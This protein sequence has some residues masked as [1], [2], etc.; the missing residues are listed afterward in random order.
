[1]GTGTRIAVDWVQSS[2]SYGR[3]SGASSVS[4]AV[5]QVLALQRC[6]IYIHIR[7]GALLS[8]LLESTFLWATNAGEV[9]GIL[10][11]WYWF[12]KLCGSF[13]RYWVEGQPD[14]AFWWGVFCAAVVL[15]RSLTFPPFRALVFVAGC[16]P[17]FIRQRRSR[18]GA[19]TVFLLLLL[20]LIS[21]IWAHYC[22]VLA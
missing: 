1:M 16:Q 15:F 19:T 2:V 22:D 12:D 5:Y 4:F 20:L 13:T 18:Q 14:L 3:D 8:P 17:G 6:F 9:P 10:A 11:V 7:F 21:Y